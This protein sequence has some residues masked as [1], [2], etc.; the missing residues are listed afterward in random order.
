MHAGDLETSVMLHLCPDQVGP[1]RVDHVPEVS[2]EFFD[3]A[4]MKSYCPDGV[5]GRAGRAT[6]EKGRQA[7]QIMVEETVKYVR[8]TFARLDALD[9]QS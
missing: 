3:Y 4:V 6:A 1:D 5:W 7:M 2:G 9:S 8:T